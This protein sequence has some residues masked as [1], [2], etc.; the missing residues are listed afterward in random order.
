MDC[1]CEELLSWRRFEI[2]SGII[3]LSRLCVSRLKDSYRTPPELTRLVPRG[4]SLY[5]D[6][7]H[8]RAEPAGNWSEKPAGLKIRGQ[9]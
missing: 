1:K 2:I 7:L 4:R 3:Q 6:D 8:A 5:A 9:R